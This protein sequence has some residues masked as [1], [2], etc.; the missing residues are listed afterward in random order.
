MPPSNKVWH[1]SFYKAFQ[2]LRV[3]KPEHE[4]GH[5]HF[6]KSLQFADH[7]RT[8]SSH[9]VLLGMA[10]HLSRLL[11]DTCCTQIG[12][13]DVRRI[14]AYSRTVVFQNGNL[15]GVLSNRA[16]IKIPPV[17]VASHYC[18]GF[19][20]TTTANEERN[21]GFGLWFTIGFADTVL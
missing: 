6:M 1:N 7:F 20:F 16:G 11:R 5:T 15:A 13:L 10:Y 9:E 4:M 19:S 3:Q 18:K 2:G 8:V 12:Q 14:P 21:W 17:R